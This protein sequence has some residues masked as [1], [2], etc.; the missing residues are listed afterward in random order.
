MNAAKR[1]AADGTVT[2]AVLPELLV[3][4]GRAPVK[5]DAAIGEFAGLL[6]D[7]L[8]GE[9]RVDGEADADDWRTLLLLVSRT[10]EELM[11]EG[12]IAKAWAATGRSHFEIREIDY[13]EVLRERAGADDAAA[14]D[15]I[16]QFCLQ[17]NLEGSIDERALEVII[18]ALDNA[19]RFG[20]LIEAIQTASAGDTSIG[21]RA[22]ALLGLIQRAIETLKERREVDQASILQTIAD[23]AGR[24]TPDMMLSFLQQARQKTESGEP[25]LAAAIVDRMGDGTI[26]TFVAGSVVA[27]RGATERLAL[28]FESLVP[29]FDRK[30]HLL[31]LARS[32]AEQTPLGGESGFDDLWQGAADML[33]SY[34]DKSFVSEEYGRE[35]S[36][37]R[38][39]AIEV[40]RVSD[41]PP[42]RVQGW[43][44]TVS[45]EAVRELDLA[46]IHDLL[47]I[48]NDP[49]TWQAIASV[50]VDQIERRTLAGDIA[51]AQALLNVLIAER[52][53][54][55]RAELRPAAESVLTKLAGGQIVRHIVV[56]LRKVEDAD[57]EPLSNICHAIGPGVVRPLAFALAVEENNR[58]I[59]HLRELLLGFGAAGRQ[60]VEQPRRTRRTRRM[61]A[62][63][64]STC[65]A[66]RLFGGREAL[67]ELASMLD[68]ADEHAGVQRESIRAIVE[69]G[70]EEAF[71]ILEHALV[72]GN[73]SRDTILQQ[74]IGLR[75][76]KA[77]PLLCLH[78]LSHTLRRA[79]GR[80]SRCMR[81]SIEGAA[82]IWAPHPASDTSM[83]RTILLP[84]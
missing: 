71:A 77:I 42:D 15:R 76:D 52:G 2:I 49:P 34:S 50:G 45:D 26:A 10:P 53:D 4:E 33:M 18:S 31:N 19:D 44:A 27:E 21:A 75:D 56:H 35:L 1:I 5:P 13:A 78:V 30:E 81:R 63:R 80:A 43:L 57:V 61:S 48:E 64:R 23:S 70:T 84:R 69:I 41:D 68:D 28:A 66:F 82:A 79:A 32:N 3:I 54:E 17:G 12:G 72:G 8:V 74:L 39:Q 58:A 47:R 55:G 24:M 20:E 9:L 25:P 38:S 59:K 73:A 14:W 67:L 62:S 36:G 46:L 29:E 40:E 51:T 60:S 37:T 65:C 22:A 7:R 11:D 16:I 6:H 83:L